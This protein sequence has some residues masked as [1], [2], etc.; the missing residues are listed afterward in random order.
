MKIEDEIVKDKQS[1]LPGGV[2]IREL[3]DGVQVKE[4]PNIVTKNGCTTEVFRN[5]WGLTPYQVV[6][7]IYASLRAET[8]SAWHYHKLQTDH[9]FVTQGTVKLVLFDSRESS[10]TQGAVN[11]FH[12][13]RMRPTLVMI[14]PNVVHGLQNL[15]SMESGFINFF[16]HEYQYD[17]PDEYRLSVDS[18]NIP[19]RF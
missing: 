17:A 9:I 4:M 16:D 2:L 10:S 3:I 19:Y 12:L 6:H 1:V 18:P 5:D 8:I 11:V 14:P 7:M 13:S 15:E